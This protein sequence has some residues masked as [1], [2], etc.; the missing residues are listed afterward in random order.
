MNSFATEWPVSRWSRLFLSSFSKLIRPIS[1][2]PLNCPIAVGRPAS[3][4]STRSVRKS[5]L[6]Q[7]L[8]IRSISKNVRT[9]L[10]RSGALMVFPTSSKHPSKAFRCFRRASIWKAYIRKVLI[11]RVSFRMVCIRKVP[12]GLHS[13]GFHL[14]SFQ[15]SRK[16]SIWTVQF[17]RFKVNHARF[18]GSPQHAFGWA[19]SSWS[20]TPPR[21]PLHWNLFLKK[22]E[23]PHSR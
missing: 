13:K 5:E 16:S 15:R 20:K 7:L 8:I 4:V 2:S 22:R 21:N 12:N 17:E 18:S 3:A 19:I 9:F 6:L 10:F 23:T 11:R 1:R 14:K